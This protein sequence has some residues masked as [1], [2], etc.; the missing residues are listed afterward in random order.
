VL[1]LGVAQRIDVREILRTTGGALVAQKCLAPDERNGP[2][3]K[4][5]RCEDASPSFFSIVPHDRSLRR[6]Q[7]EGTR[8]IWRELWC[9]CGEFTVM[10]HPFERRGEPP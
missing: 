4:R 2:G 8:T 3:A 1:H 6:Y 5:T 7:S 9:E 10:E